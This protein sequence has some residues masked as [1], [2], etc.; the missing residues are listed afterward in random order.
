MNAVDFRHKY[1]K[2]CS[3]ANKQTPSFFSPVSK[4]DSYG[5]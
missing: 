3:Q 2:E 1:R 5:V 4:D